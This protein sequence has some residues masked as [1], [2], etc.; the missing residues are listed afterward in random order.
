MSVLSAF[1]LGVTFVEKELF[2]SIT[3]NVEERDKIGFIGANGVS[4]SAGIT[5]PDHI[6]ASV[7]S[8]VV[9][10]SQTVYI[11]ADHSKFGQIASVTF[12]QLGQ[13]KIITD[14]LTDKKFLTKAN[15][16]EVM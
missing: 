3:F 9:Q 12:A 4:L 11:L 6:A 5:T 10:N 8:T 7:K 15:I 1:D 16:K 13:A 2:S 14:K